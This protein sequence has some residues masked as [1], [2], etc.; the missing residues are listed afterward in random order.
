L[1]TFI[2]TNGMRDIT[3]KTE[4]LQTAV[5][6]GEVYCAAGSVAMIRDHS[7]PCRDM[8]E[9]ARIAA[10]LAAKQTCRLIPPCHPAGIDA[11]EMEFGSDIITPA[12]GARG[13]I[14]VRAALKSIGRTAVEMEALTAVSIASLAIYEQLKEVDDQL[15]IGGARVLA[16]TGGK[17]DRKY[18]S[19]PPGCAVL[20][21]SDFVAAGKR[22]DRSGKIV[23]EMLEA[24]GA[25]VS[26]Y[27][28]VPDQKGMIQTI[29]RSWVQ[30]DIPFI[31]TTGGTGLGDQA[32]DAVREILERDADGI[33]TA[34]FNHGWRRT[35]LAMMSRVVAGTAGHTTIVTLPGSSRGARQS[36]QAV[37]PA[38]FHARK[39]LK[40]AGH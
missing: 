22:E 31:F 38:I 23:K 36:L 26:E 9:T 37:L 34:I 24:S 2:K 6:A 21:C 28:V 11:M 13:V 8:F 14:T 20:V 17:G 29:I 7:L 15:E 35:P 10:M 3:D 18:F 25:R 39:I 4:T 12:E 16:K 30:K 40:G 32:V 1:T 5:A 19:L 27:Q 33:A